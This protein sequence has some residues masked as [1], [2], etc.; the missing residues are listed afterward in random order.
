MQ[1][2]S[3]ASAGSGEAP[4]AVAPWWHTLLV[5]L[6]LAVG[7]IVSWRQ[8]GLS[9]V[10]VS[11]LSP[12][13]SSYFVVLAEE[14]VVVLLIWFWLRRSGLGLGELIGQRWRGLGSFFR[15][16]GIAA[17]FLVITVPLVGA[18]THF[19]FP[20]TN[21][22]LTK[23]TPK[24]P[25]ELGVWFVLSATGGFCEEIIFRGYLSR[26]F[27]GWMKSSWAG[28]IGQAILFGLAHGYY[29]GAMAVIV[30]EG[31]FYGLLAQWRKSLLP[32]ILA[33]GLQD[34]LGG[35]LSYLS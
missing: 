26:Q 32:G 22:N 5:I 34:A 9:G 7:S 17:A 33:H 28:L 16:I 21:I 6:P 20:H 24:T 14:W 11:G 13:L 27:S 4:P 8:G 31:L 19:A 1:S 15:D 23:V 10:H 12:R 30:V 25:V 35:L 2:T 3:I 29:H 18:L